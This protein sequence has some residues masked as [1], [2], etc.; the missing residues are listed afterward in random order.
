MWFHSI[1]DSRHYENT[2]FDSI[3]DSNKNH[4]ILIRFMIQ[5]GIVYKSA[6]HLCTLHE[7]KL[8]FV[9]RIKFIRSRLSIFLLMYLFAIR[10][11]SWADY[12]PERL[13]QT[14]GPRARWR[15][16][17]NTGRQ[18]IRLFHTPVCSMSVK[19]AHAQPSLSPYSAHIRDTSERA[20]IYTQRA[21]GH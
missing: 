4:L 12:Q 9:S 21:P 19:T 13:L 14:I 11:R 3:H 20:E 8:R 17:H 1:H 6:V 7:S 5:V 15:N 10:V 18:S 16:G 2:W